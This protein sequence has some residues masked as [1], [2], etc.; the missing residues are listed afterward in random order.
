MRCYRKASSALRLLFFGLTKRLRRFD[1]LSNPNPKPNQK[2]YPSPQ[3]CKNL[4]PRRCL[5]MQLLT[6]EAGSFF[7]RV[8]ARLRRL[9]P[10]LKKS[11]TSMETI[12]TRVSIA[13]WNVANMS[14][15][16]NHCMNQIIVSNR[17]ISAAVWLQLMMP[18]WRHCHLHSTEFH[19]TLL[20][21]LLHCDDLHLLHF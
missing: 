2:L 8:S 20:V 16:D 11:K 12:S 1:H 13:R 10:W 7:R 18:S 15:N 5:H 17:L 19:Q 6:L 21:D 9:K 3:T 4:D 14:H